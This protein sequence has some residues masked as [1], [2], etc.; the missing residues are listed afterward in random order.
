MAVENG[1]NDRSGHPPDRAVDGVRARS[2]NLVR[3]VFAAAGT[4]TAQTEMR[5]SAASTAEA[6]GEEMDCDADPDL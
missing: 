5:S 3:R 4:D 2:A 6:S 1:V